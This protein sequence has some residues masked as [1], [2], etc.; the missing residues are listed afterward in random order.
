MIKEVVLVFLLGS[1]VNHSLGQLPGIRHTTL[2]SE[3]F[4]GGNFIELGIRSDGKFGASGKPSNFFGRRGSYSG[5]GMIGDADGFGVKTDLR[6]DYFLPGSP[7][8]G[9][10]FGFSVS[11]SR[12][13][14]KNSATSVVDTS[15]ASIASATIFAELSD[16]GGSLTVTQ[17]ISLQEDDTLFKNEVTLEN[18]GTIPISEVRFMRSHDPDN[19]VDYGGSYATINTIERSMAVGDS[20]S[21]VSAGSGTSDS[22]YTD[23]GN[24]EAVILYATTDPRGR[25]SYGCCGLA[26]SGLYDSNI[27][28][29]P[30]ANGT[31]NTAD[32]YIS[33]AFDVGTLAPGEST[34]FVY[35]TVLDNADINEILNELACLEV[36]PN[37]AECDQ[38]ECF[39]CSS[40]YYLEANTCLPCPGTGCSVCTS[41]ECSECFEGFYIDGTSCTEC[42]TTFDNCYECTSSECTAC[43]DGYHVD[44]GE[45]TECSITFEN[46][47]ECTSSEC[48]VCVDSYLPSD[49]VCAPCLSVL[50]IENCIECSSL[51]CT[52]CADPFFAYYGDCV[53]CS[54]YFGA[55]DRCDLARY[56][57][58]CSPGYYDYYGYCYSCPSNCLECSSGSSCSICNSDYYVN[59]SGGCSACTFSNCAVCAETECTT[60]NEGYFFDGTKC[61]C[62]FDNCN[63][64]TSSGCTACDV[65]Y[66]VDSGECTECSTTFTGCTECSPS[67][68]F[69]CDVGYHIDSG[70]CTECST[71]FT[72]CNECTSSECSSCDIG[73]HID[74]G[75]CTECSTT[76]TGCNE[77]TS[78]DVGYHVV[79]VIL[80]ITLIV[81]NVQSV[82][83][84]LLVVT[85]VHQVNVLAVMLDIMLIVENV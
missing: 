34:T 77:C 48:T 40:G 63:E 44:S 52:E 39:T 17:D 24:K 1:F 28:D 67:E 18:V 33:I 55:C 7:E 6:I 74:S 16:G 8:E 56:C 22:Y 36:V 26:P 30:P 32:A 9:F 57:Y 19:T 11:G 4:L 5:I 3:V 82:P 13:E 43:D 85:N 38:V 35:Y 69:S 58:D 72:G 42:S 80:G 61:A 12:F 50:E 27:W 51:G 66:H 31:S 23:A 84:P 10:Y 76:F 54:Y 45:C 20:N 46:C 71:T 49:G 65:G 29:S 68:C 83:L 25:V 53:A 2:S 73:Y 41:T 64:C 60:C 59:S 78:S 14:S 47:N 79:A 15:S 70:A 81:E 21:V 62:S 37:C 75:E